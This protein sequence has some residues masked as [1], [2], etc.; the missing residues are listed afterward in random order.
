MSFAL[1]CPRGFCN[2]GDL[3]RAALPSSQSRSEV[4]N[5]LAA[6]EAEIAAVKQRGRIQLDESTLDLRKKLGVAEETLQV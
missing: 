5:T 4:E 6:A 3:F 2:D 1:L